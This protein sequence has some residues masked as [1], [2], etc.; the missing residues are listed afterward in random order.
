VRVEDE[1]FIA[2]LEKQGKSTDVGQLEKA[3]Q[4]YQ[5]LMETPK[6]KLS[7]RRDLKSKIDRFTVDASMAPPTQKPVKPESEMISSP[8]YTQ[9]KSRMMGLLFD[10]NNQVVK[11]E[12]Y[13][14]FFDE[15]NANP[16]YF[17]G[18]EKRLLQDAGFFPQE[19]PKQDDVEINKLFEERVERPKPVKVEQDK[20]P[21]DSKGRPA[22]LMYKDERQKPKE[23][24]V[25]KPK[26]Q[27]PE[28]PLPELSPEE[29]QRIK[30]KYK[31]P[32]SPYGTSSL[33]ATMNELDNEYAMEREIR[34]E[35]ERMRDASYDTLNRMEEREK[36]YFK[37]KEERE[38][39]ERLNQTFELL[40]MSPIP[41]PQPT[42]AELKEIKHREVIDNIF[43]SW[44][45]DSSPENARRLIDM[46]HE[47]EIRGVPD[48]LY[49]Y[50]TPEDVKKITPKQK[51][52]YQIYLLQKQNK[53]KNND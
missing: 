38:R 11:Q 49:D 52:F 43:K 44:E 46:Y 47:N 15:V 4:A 34:M 53:G 33:Q 29:E 26:E 45:E 48:T 28:L 31:T 51:T 24:P 21:L 19:K 2:Y 50:F 32:T 42:E 36:E 35:R 8:D 40:G 27:R 25:V 10:D 23:Q 7:T 41:E 39:R 20:G 3:Y 30:D 18:I 5:Q 14:G 17:S 37:E 1:E 13:P 9:E 16:Q 22:G 12:P 6:Y